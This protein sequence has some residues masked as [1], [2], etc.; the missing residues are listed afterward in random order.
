MGRERDLV[1]NKDEKDLVRVKASLDLPIAAISFQIACNTLWSKSW[2][3]RPSDPK[4]ALRVARNALKRAS[5]F[6]PIFNHCYIPCNPG[7]AGNLIF[8]VDEN[9]IFCCGLDLSDF[10]ELESLFRSSESDP[11]I[12]KR[13]RSVSEKSA[14]SSSNFS[15]KSL[16]MVGSAGARTPRWVEFWSDIA[17]DRHR[18]NSSSSSSSS[19]ERFFEMPKSG[20][21]RGERKKRKNK[22]KNKKKKMWLAWIF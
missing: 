2:G 13:Q 1:R 6:I 17:V 9:R 4:K 21:S 11:Q 5:F 19:P 3:P 15:F 10:F 18:R 14:G 7:L 8:F 20:K 22:G 16:D 12:L